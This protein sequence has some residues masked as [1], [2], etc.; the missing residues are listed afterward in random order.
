MDGKT[1]QPHGVNRRE[2]LGKAGRLLLMGAGIGTGVVA[3][4]GTDVPPATPTSANLPET[5]KS[6]N[7]EA[8]RQRIEAFS[9]EQASDGH[10]LRQFIEDM[11]DAYLSLT[12]TPRLTRDDILGEGKMNTYSSSADFVTAIQTV[13]PEYVSSPTQWGYTDYKTGKIFISMENLKQQALASGNT[14][15]EALVDAVWHEV[16]HRD[17]TERTSGTLLNNPQALLFSPV[18]GINEEIRRYRGGT[19]YTDT[20]YGMVRFDE[21]LNESIT[22][23][24]MVQQLGMPK[25]MSAGEY[26]QNGVDSFPKLTQVA[27]ISLDR[28]YEY[29]ATSDLEG[30]AIAIGNVLPGTAE[31]IAK[32]INLFTSIHYADAQMIEDSGALSVIPS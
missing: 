5:R 6:I 11:G 25:G 28:L 18:S 27:G 20:Y 9:W 2:L 21:V 16:G 29:H 31:P 3:C 8:V 32:G 19:A 26:Y 17:V 4:G 23:L 13:Y 15:G 10:E 7:P 22:A 1:E 12:N 24:R 14:A 30:L